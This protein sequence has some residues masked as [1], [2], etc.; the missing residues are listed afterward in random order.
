LVHKPEFF[1]PVMLGL[2]YILCPR[3]F[4]LRRFLQVEGSAG[5]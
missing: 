1:Q 3:R 4:T 2:H 5:R